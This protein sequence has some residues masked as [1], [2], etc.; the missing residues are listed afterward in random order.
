MAEQRVNVNREE[1]KIA[2][3]NIKQKY[4]ELQYT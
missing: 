2:Y 4:G 1:V 3:E